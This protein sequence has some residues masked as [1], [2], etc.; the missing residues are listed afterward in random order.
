MERGLPGLRSSYS[1]R[2]GIW[3]RRALAPLADRSG[4][5]VRTLSADRLVVQAVGAQ[6]HDLGTYPHQPGR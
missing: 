4:E 6:K 3:V 2:S 5:L 1:A